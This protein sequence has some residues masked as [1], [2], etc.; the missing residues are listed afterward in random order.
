[1]V[2]G[3]YQKCR[4][5]IFTLSRG[6]RKIDIRNT[7]SFSEVCSSIHPS[8]HADLQSTSIGHQDHAMCFPL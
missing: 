5:H 6:D 4:H 7:A 1:M 2:L 3:Q 8:I